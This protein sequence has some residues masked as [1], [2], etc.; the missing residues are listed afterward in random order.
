MSHA[1]V[2]AA[3]KR[4]SAYPHPV[5]EVI[6]LQTHISDIFLTGEFAYKMKKPVVFSFL[7]FSTLNKRRFFCQEEDRLNSRLAPSVY[8]GVVPVTAEPSGARVD[9]PGEVLDWLVK[10]RELSQED[11]GSAVIARGGLNRSRIDQVVEKLVPFYQEAATGEG[12]DKYG[13]PE[14]VRFN[15][16]ENYEQT[17]GTVGI[18]L[19]LERYAD[20]VRYTDD[21]LE[22]RGDLFRRRVR[23][24]FIREGHGDL[25]LDNICFEKKP[26]IYDCI[27]FNPRLRCL[28][29]ACDLGFLAMDLDF[30]GREDLS[31][32][33]I[34]AYAARSGD[35]ELPRIVDFYKCYRAYVR[36]KIM[37]LTWDD[38]QV[39]G[40]AKSDIL[41]LAK[42]YFGLAHRYS[43]GS[44]RPV[45]V[46]LH[47]LMASGKSALGRWL[48]GRFGWPVLSSDLIRKKLAG[49]T[50][51]TKAPE[52]Y[53]R[54]L[55]SRDMS[56]QVYGALYDS[57]G[58]FL[59][60]GCSV[61]LDGSFQRSCHRE[62]A[63]DLARKMN[64]R[65]VF[66][67]AVCSPAEQR[68]RLLSREKKKVSSDGRLEL[69]A[70]QARNFDPP[71][72]A[73]E[74]RLI[75]INTDGPKVQTRALTEER[76][77]EYGLAG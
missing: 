10:M 40:R 33:L 14:A 23:G 34:E 15:V 20:L 16:A 25:H 55:Y 59:A 52:K 1:E 6:H 67:K 32:Y 66:L 54:G 30:N 42:R 7:D 63:L 48:W 50:S 22:R 49:L 11:M 41:A 43:G 76:L 53:G 19:S 21:Y 74:G 77:E 3:L 38:P 4:P 5:E 68:R 37:A 45:L 58:S 24:G 39:R 75:T 28:D 71:G 8:L 9:G 61:I 62:S 51:T 27:E 65:I 64:A 36:G 2:V 56:E 17:R 44:H 47:G 69:V 35:E 13:A 18:A 60:A 57:A 26:L 29:V 31:R 70:A 72:K 12:I 46:V 73:E